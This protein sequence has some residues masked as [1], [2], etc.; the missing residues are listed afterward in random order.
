MKKSQQTEYIGETNINGEVLDLDSNGM[1]NEESLN[2]QSQD[3]LP[4]TAIPEPSNGAEVKNYLDQLQRLQAEFS[5]YRKRIEKE[6][7]ELS[8]FYKS[9]LVSALLP[10]IDDFERMLNHADDHSNE[11]LTGI[12]LIF[13]K[14]MDILQT[15]G[16]KPIVAVGQKFDPAIHEAVL[17]EPTDN[18]TDETVIEEWQR[19]YFFN[20]RLI[21]PARVKVS[22]HEVTREK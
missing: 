5:N 8:D 22:K 21:R 3:N 7:A 15:Q 18:G 9:E 20:D 12:R 4:P 17:V 19:G 10:I 1:N 2:R 6:K 16:L 14:L 13:Q 11:L